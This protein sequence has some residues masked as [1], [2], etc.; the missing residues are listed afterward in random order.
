V[1]PGKNDIVQLQDEITK[2][3]NGDAA[4]LARGIFGDT[5][6][7]PDAQSVSTDQLDAL[8]RSKYQSGTPADRDWLVSEA[9][10]DPDQFLKVADRIGVV[11]PPAPNPVQPAPPANPPPQVAPAPVP[12]AVA[13]PPPVAPPVPPPPPVSPP[14]IVPAQPPAPGPLAPGPS[15][16]LGPNGLPLS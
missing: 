10:R 7:H 1:P 13:A 9:Q 11:M 2:E 8:Y 4:I 16:I 15:Q 5:A 3:I 6:N 14:L 12:T